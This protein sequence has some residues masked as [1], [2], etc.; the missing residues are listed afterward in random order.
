M[1]LHR[2]YLS[3]VTALIAAASLPVTPAAHAQVISNTASAQWTDNSQ[4]GGQPGQTLSNRVDVTVTSRPPDQP[5]IKTY[6]ILNEG[7][8]K[9]VPLRPTLCGGSIIAAQSVMDSSLIFALFI[10]ITA[11]GML[12]YEAVR[13]IERRVLHRFS[14][15]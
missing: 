4:I 8:N 1:T 3:F 9:S 11:L 10:V 7:G 14:K 12:L 13:L 6:R 5:V 15:G 2:K